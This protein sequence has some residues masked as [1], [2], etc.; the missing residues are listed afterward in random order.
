MSEHLLFAAMTALV[1][2]PLSLALAAAGLPLTSAVLLVNPPKRV[3]VFRDKYGQQTATLSLLF[4][5]VAM[6]SLAGGA[7]LL[8]LNFPAA[9]SFWLGWPLPL[10]PIAGLLFIAAALAVI[11]RASWQSLKDKRP[12]H[13]AIGVAATLSGWGLGYLFLSFLRH[14]A[15]SSADP[16]ADPTLFLPP[17]ESAAWTHL[18]LSVAL[19]IAMA[20]AAAPLYLIH[21]RDKDDFGRDYYNYALKLAAKWAL[22][23]TLA[24][25]ACLGVIAA[26]L[27]PAAR[28]L[29]IRPVFFW[30]GCSGLGCFLLACLLWMLV[31][32]NQN[33][34]RLK[35]HCAA[36]FL[37][38]WCGISGV[39]LAGVKFFFG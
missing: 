12:L 20:G 22:G 30:G 26:G 16:G 21:R 29:P 35:L 11:F 24:S 28:E 5:I 6:A 27:W 19:T 4:G 18:P 33:P 10:T 2:L 31:I 1:C 8:Q 9:A 39:M 34:L 23:A 17:L 7:V 38:A 36:A 3:K 14:F 13:A 25:L 37:L 15:V 32:R